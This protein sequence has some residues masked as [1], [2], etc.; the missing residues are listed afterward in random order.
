VRK[1][2]RK[3]PPV[4]PDHFRC[5]PIPPKRHRAVRV[6]ARPLALRLE[7]VLRVVLDPAAYARR[8]AFR[9]RR[10]ANPKVGLLIDERPP[11]RGRRFARDAIEAAR[12]RAFTLYLPWWSSG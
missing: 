3:L 10:G 4:D 7:A 11:T 5:D 8:L 9:L 2:S 1:P 12:Q 6:A